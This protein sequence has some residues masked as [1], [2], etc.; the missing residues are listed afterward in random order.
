MA[1]YTLSP[2][3]VAWAVQPV[4]DNRAQLG[5]SSTAPANDVI[6]GYEADVYAACMSTSG[7]YDHYTHQAMAE[8]LADW[9]V[10]LITATGV[11]T[12]GKQVMNGW[13]VP[14]VPCG[15]R[16]EDTHHDPRHHIA[17]YKRDN[18]R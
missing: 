10:R 15:K 18:D 1:P 16:T 17:G 9:T 4:D 12:A 13:L 11:H 14:I 5:I 3:D 2:R 6:G 7:Y 8:A